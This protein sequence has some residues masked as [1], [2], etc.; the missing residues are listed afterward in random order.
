MTIKRV[1]IDNDI[2]EEVGWSW[3]GCQDDIETLM[4]CGRV[5]DFESENGDEIRID[6]SEIGYWLKALT[7]AKKYF[8]AQALEEF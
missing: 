1:D 4:V 3:K 7:E 6:K 8:D 5:L 2:S